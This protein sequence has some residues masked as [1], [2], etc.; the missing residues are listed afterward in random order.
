[1]AEKKEESLIVAQID[2]Y[3]VAWQR[4]GFWFFNW[5]KTKGSSQYICCFFFSMKE[6]QSVNL[7][8]TLSVCYLPTSTPGKIKECRSDKQ[9][10]REKTC[11]FFFLSNK[12][13]AILA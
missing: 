6:L 11:L 4:V 8:V 2:R 12:V 1:M 3:D 9:P 5:V 10:K 7:S 13:W